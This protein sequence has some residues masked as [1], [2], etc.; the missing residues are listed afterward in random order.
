MIEREEEEEGSVVVEF[1]VVVRG[2]G[3]SRKLALGLCRLSW[4]FASL[5][6]FSPFGVSLRQET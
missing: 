3:E 4:S 5:I 6:F 1:V 2:G